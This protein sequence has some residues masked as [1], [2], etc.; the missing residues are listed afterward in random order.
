[1][2]NLHPL[3]SRREDILVTVSD[4]PPAPL[5]RKERGANAVSGF[6]DYPKNK[7]STPS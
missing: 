7:K 5:F 3:K 4:S 2:K 1:M 6:E